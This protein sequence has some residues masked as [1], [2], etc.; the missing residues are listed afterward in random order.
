MSDPSPNAPATKNDHDPLRFWVTLVCVFCVVV[1]VIGIL[2]PVTSTGC[3]GG[4]H[5]GERTYRTASDLRSAII[6][7]QTEHKR[8]PALPGLPADGDALL[9][10]SEANGLIS[11]MTGAPGNALAAQL[12]PRGI[13]YFT[14]RSAKSAADPGLWYSGSGAHLKDHWGNYYR[15]IMDSDYNNQVDIKYPDGSVEA[16]YNVFVIHSLGK[17]GVMDR[18]PGFKDDDIFAQ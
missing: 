11:V 7:Y 18:T 14:E 8:F 3:I 15:V 13:A 1:V 6:M 12:N 16:V 4:R 2:I 17:N 9:D 5:G 10:T